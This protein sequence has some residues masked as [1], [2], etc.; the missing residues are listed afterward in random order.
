M[1]EHPNPTPSWTARPVLIYGPHK[2]GST[3]LQRLLDGH[4]SIWCYPMELKLK[5][6]TLTPPASRL[7]AA[8]ANRKFCQLQGF[9]HEKWDR[10][11]FLRLQKELNETCMVLGGYIQGMA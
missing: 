6:M 2:S 9:M 10:E 4:S 1:S 3:L 7:D 11:K 8:V 5:F